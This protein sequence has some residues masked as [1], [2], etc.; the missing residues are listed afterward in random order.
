ML[1]CLDYY[2]RRKVTASSDHRLRVFDKLPDETW[3]LVDTF[4]G[5]D[6]EI[7]DVSKGFPW[8]YCGYAVAR[9]GLLSSLH[10]PHRGE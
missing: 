9:Y 4:K 2:G 7:L 5:H 1:I 8:R 10:I 6:A 3:K